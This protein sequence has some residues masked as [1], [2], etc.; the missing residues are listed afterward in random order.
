[1]PKKEMS[2]QERE[3]IKMLEECG[4]PYTA[5]YLEMFGLEDGGNPWFS[6]GRNNRER[7]EEFYKKCVEEGHPWDYYVEAS[8]EDAIL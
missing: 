6:N 5:K 7:Q 8:P 2:E 3:A 1:M 4:L